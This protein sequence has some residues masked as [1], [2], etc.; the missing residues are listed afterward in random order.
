VVEIRARTLTDSSLLGAPGHY[1]DGLQALGALLHVELDF[2]PL[3]E[4]AISV[5]LNSRKMDEYIL[6]ARA[7]DESETLCIIE[8]L[9]CALLSHFK[10]S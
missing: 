9:N 1:V 8:P 3:L 6:T 2:R 10:N 4:T 7:L 5:T